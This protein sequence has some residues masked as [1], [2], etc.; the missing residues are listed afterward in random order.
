MNILPESIKTTAFINNTRHTG[1]TIELTNSH[2][3]VNGRR[4]AELPPGDVHLRIITGSV[5]M[6]GVLGK[7]DTVCCHEWQRRLMPKRYKITR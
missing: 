1:R 3:L 2:V 4:A 5:R 7:I 6:A